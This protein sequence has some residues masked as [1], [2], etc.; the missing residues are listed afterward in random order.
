MQITFDVHRIN[1]THVSRTAEIKGV[2]LPVTVAA[3]EV[4]L[5]SNHG[6]SFQLRFELPADIKEAEA[7]FVPGKKVVWTV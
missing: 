5:V 6:T 4:E 7:K 1:M 3:L 2:M